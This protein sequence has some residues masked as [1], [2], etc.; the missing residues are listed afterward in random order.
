MAAHERQMPPTSTGFSASGRKLR[1]AAIGY[2]ALL[3]V[4]WLVARFFRLKALDEYPVS[5]FLSF[6]L[7]FAPYWFFGFGAAELLRARL[8]TPSVTVPLAAVLALPYFVLEAPRGNVQASMAATLIAIPVL[9]AAA[10]KIW[11]RAGNWA[12]F[13]VL[14]AI[15]LLIDLSLL[16]TAWPLRVEGV[17][18]WPPG[19]GGFPKLMMANVALYAYLVVKPVEGVGYDLRPRMDDLKYGLREFLF[20]AP[21][22]LPLGF[23][24][25][26]LRWHGG[27]PRLWVA[28]AAWT[29]TFFFVALPEEL[30]FRGLVQNL[31]ERHVGRRRAFWLASVLFGLSH[32]NK[33]AAFN[34]R[35]VLLATIAGLFYG[36]AW[37]AQ[38]RLFA[39]SITHA[40]VD[41][42]WSIWFR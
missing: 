31:L 20:Y 36:R 26:F 9:V 6:T 3:I 37:L 16:T 5:T 32:F 27:S 24:L 29:F 30:F 25:G 1:L 39:S 41:T 35:Y 21:I 40:T 14:G 28:P 8:K 42:V 33:G 17:S 19:L 7:L 11:P 23:L 15:G 38:R 18:T 13:L 2:C 4:F 10:L 12:D 34:W 22:V